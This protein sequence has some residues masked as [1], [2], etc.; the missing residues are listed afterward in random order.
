MLGDQFWLYPTSF[1]ISQRYESNGNPILSG[2]G[3]K[4]KFEKFCRCP[5]TSSRVYSDRCG[6]FTAGD[7]PLC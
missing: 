5:P 7:D 2:A 1:L 4:V 3:F 6:E